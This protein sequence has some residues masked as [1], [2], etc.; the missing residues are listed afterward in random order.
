MRMNVSDE[1]INLTNMTD[2]TNPAIYK[3][4]QTA[5]SMASVRL[6]NVEVAYG[7]EMLTLVVWDQAHNGQC[8]VV[9]A[10]KQ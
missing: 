5:L 2:L 8:L 1:P 4:Y 6:Q 10:R 7:D 3:V 9:I